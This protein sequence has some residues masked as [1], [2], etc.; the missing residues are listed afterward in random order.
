MTGLAR[1]FYAV[2][3]AFAAWRARRGAAVNKRWLDRAERW[4]KRAGAP[5][6]GSGAR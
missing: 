3:A 5:S 2:A 6:N 4:A 1:T